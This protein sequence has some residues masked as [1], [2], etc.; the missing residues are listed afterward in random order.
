[1]PTYSLRRFSQIDTLKSIG[2]AHLL[3]LLAPHADFLQQRGVPLPSSDT[4]AETLG[5]EA[6]VSVLMSPAEDTPTALVDDFYLAH[7]M[8]TPEAVDEL[9]R[10]AESEGLRLRVGD[11]PTP[12]DVAI[13]VLLVL[14]ADRNLLERKHAEQLLV[15][16]RSFEHFQSEADPRPLAPITQR[17]LTLIEDELNSWFDSRKRGRG[18]RVL[19]WTKGSGVWFLIRH[20]D[21]YRREGA[22]DHGRSASILYR[23]ERHDVVVYDATSGELRIHAPSPKDKD[24]YRLLFGRH[25]F[26]SDNYFPGRAK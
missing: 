3:A 21:P 8:A 4:T 6:L 15:R 23:P 25:L 5:L 14:L 19:T 18:V 10:A 11:R 22:I 12:A 9:L 16:P 20:G 1:V 13:Q 24:Q 26:G 17:Q 2:P 7:E